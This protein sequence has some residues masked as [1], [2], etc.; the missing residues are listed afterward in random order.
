MNIRSPIPGRRGERGFTLL[1]ALVALL[2]V[3][4]GMLAVAS[5]QVTLSSNSDYAKQRSE[6]LR[7]AQEKLEELRS[8]SSVD[9]VSNSTTQMDW[10]D[11]ASCSSACSDTITGNGTWMSNSYYSNTNYTRTWTV[12]RDGSNSAVN[13]S[14]QKWIRVSVAW[15]DR[16]NTAQSVTLT[17]TISRSDPV[18][19]KLWTTNSGSTTTRKPKNRNIDIPYPATDFGNG[20]SGFMPGGASGRYFI[21]DNSTGNVKYVC[22]GTS[23]VAQSSN[24]TGCTQT[25]AY[26]LS[27][28][29]YWYTANSSPSASDLTVTL[30]DKNN[31]LQTVP[32]LDYSTSDTYGHAN[33]VTIEFFD[34]TASATKE[35]FVKQ[36]MVDSS[37]NDIVTYNSATNHNYAFATYLCV[38]TPVLSGTTYRW[39]GMFKV[40][41]DSTHALGNTSSTYTLCRF[42]GDYDADDEM[43]NAEHPLYYRQV[44]ASLDSQNY[45]VVSGDQN[46]PTDTEVNTASSKYTNNNTLVHMNRSTGSAPYGGA[47]SSG[48]QW[49]TAEPSTS[50]PST[51]IPMN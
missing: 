32:P 5:F 1:E 24:S 36:Q 7:L 51:S 50:N 46:C 49:T 28:Y 21:F 18:N 19:M 34:P 31:N 20:T 47:V 41:L 10:D 25:T 4:F 6:A 2:I 26:L 17:S 43:A 29:I 33:G 30:T 23:V 39:Y 3:S 40:V 13:T 11:I 27:G 8:F 12:T 45:V 9:T 22:N 14:L 38:V 16:S 35:C 44:T 42:T 15:T 48:S 37:S